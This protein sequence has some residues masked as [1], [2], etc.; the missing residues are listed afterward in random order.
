M[1]APSAGLA[2][3]PPPPLAVP[4]TEADALGE[5]YCVPEPVP[6]LPPLTVPP[7]PLLAVA[8]GKRETEDCDEAVRSADVEAE[9]VAAGEEEA[10][11][12]GEVEGVA[13]SSGEGVDGGEGVAGAE[14]VA[15]EEA[16][17]LAVGSG[18]RVNT[19][20]PLAEDAREAVF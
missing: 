2:V 9:R 11:A 14:G 20:L 8:E 10:E 7:P 18:L 12:Q 19:A 6:L 4:Q 13:L 3:A 1:V 15:K 5:E 17:P 16:Q